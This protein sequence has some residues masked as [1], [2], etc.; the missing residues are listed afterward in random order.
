MD[1]QL[2]FTSPTQ[3]AIV[4]DL[5]L[6]VAQV[7]HHNAYK[8]NM[9]NLLLINKFLSFGALFSSS[10]FHFLYQCPHMELTMSFSFQHLD[11]S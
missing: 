1:W 7:K 6:S 2:G 11:Q 5:S 10:H 9:F 3:V 4:R 8:H